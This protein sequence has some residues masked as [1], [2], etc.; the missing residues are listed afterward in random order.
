MDVSQFHTGTLYVSSEKNPQTQN[1][2]F[3]FEDTFNTNYS[4]SHE[5]NDLL[6]LLERTVDLHSVQLYTKSRDVSDHIDGYVAF[7]AVKYCKDCC[8][9][10]LE[11]FA[12]APAQSDSYVNLLSRDGLKHPSK[13]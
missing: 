3:E 4:S 2:K 5:A 12:S 10:C 13:Q 11:S 7:K 6:P 9:N 8:Y 1:L